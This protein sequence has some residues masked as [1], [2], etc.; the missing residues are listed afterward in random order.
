MKTRIY[1]Y[2]LLTFAIVIIFTACKRNLTEL[3]VNPNEV[4][5]VNPALLFKQSLK[6]GAGSYNTDVNVEQWGLMTWMMYMAPKGGHS[7]GEEYVIPGGKDGFWDEQF[8]N[9]LVGIQETLNLYSD[10]VK[11]TNEIAIAKIWKVF[12]FHRMTDLWGEVPYSEALRGYDD[13]IYLPKYD[14]Q[15]EIYFHFLDDLK[16][17]SSAIDEANPL[18]T[19]DADLIYSGDLHKWRLFA[20]SLRLRL[21]INIK[22]IAPEKYNEVL[23]ELEQAE[24]FTKNDD[25]AH[26]PFNEEKKNHLYETFFTNQGTVQ[27][28]PSKFLVDMLQQKNDPRAAVFFQ[29][30][31]LSL[32]QPWL[33]P[34]Y[35]GVPNL[36]ANNSE[37]WSSYDS[38]WGDISKIGTWFLRAETPGVIMS[39]SEVCF[40]KSEAALDGFFPQSSDF[41]LKEGIKANMNFY[42]EYGEIEHEISEQKITN[43]ISNLSG[44]TLEDIIMQKWI[45]FAFENGFQAY[46]EYRRTGY[47]VLLNFNNTPIDN[48]IFP[49]R[50]PYPTSEITLNSEN[51]NNAVSRQGT[52]NE[53]TKLW[54]DVE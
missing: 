31:E 32:A 8:S 48:S 5:Y 54:W 30:T 38:N 39:Y 9:A 27:N 37:T 10:S 7:P 21:A 15:Q 51:Y 4:T 25:S 47:P 42:T 36:L 34:E 20:N 1:K 50:L 18:S 40:L 17:S 19:P 28:N 13:L 44:S 35:K 3:N 14:S 46:S 23:K 41:Y 16:A 43:Y 33:Y 26:F 52:D 6:D 53:F 24:F 2:S 12:L 49:V 22:F 45:S 29:K 11:Y